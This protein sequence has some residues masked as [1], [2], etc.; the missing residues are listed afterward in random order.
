MKLLYVVPNLNNGGGVARVLSIKTN[1]LIEK[2]GYEVHILTQNHGNSSLFYSFNEKI[3]LHDMILEGANFQFLN[4]YRKSLN[5]Q[6]ASINPDIIIVCDNGLKAF[7]VPFILNSKTPI[8]FECH[9]SIFMEE[10]VSKNMFFS[11]FLRK[12]KYSF[13]SFGASKFNKIITLSEENREEWSK[14]N[15]FVIPNPIWFSTAKE[16]DLS[17]KNVISVGRHTY[18]KGFDRLLE[19]WKKVIVKFPDWNLTI[20]GKSNPDFDLIALAKKLN[21]ENN[22]TFHEPIK[23]INEKYLEASIYLMP[24]RFEGFG[25][26]LIEAMASGLPCISYDCPCGPRAIIKDNYNG[27]LIENGNENEFVKTVS[28][29][30][31][32]E[33]LRIQIGKNSKES[34]NKYDIDEIMNLWDKLFTELVFK[35]NN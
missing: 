4:N 2:F 30:I 6:V 34:V 14:K 1:F 26:V 24:S 23:N 3:V 32:N 19:I 18:E 20:Y 13:K 11:N 31:D 10:N 15:S 12:L 21:I 25:M 7:T 16:A 35:K 17:Q 29:L 22:I 5:K 27:F 28:N 9:G 8:I 33:N